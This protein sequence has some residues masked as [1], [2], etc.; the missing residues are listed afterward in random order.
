MADLIRDCLQ[1]FQLREVSDVEPEWAT[2]AIAL[3]LPP[4][5]SWKNR[6][7][8]WVTLDG[9]A[10]FLLRR[11][12]GGSACVGTHALFAGA[13]LAQMHRRFSLLS[14][15]TAAG[16]D[17]LFAKTVSSLTRAQRPDG[18]W[19][20]DWS[21]GRSAHAES[22]ELAL[23]VT[24]HVLESL[25]YIPPHHRVPDDVA[26][27]GLGFLL[28]AVEAASESDVAS[29]YCPY[30]HAARVLLNWPV[31]RGGSRA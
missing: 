24:G 13:V 17:A 18:S 15:E 30:S 27:R 20:G 2:T 19:G 31:R 9:L 25:M 11:Q 12:Q 8:D 14:A 10:R 29:H 3:Y 1:N 5:S 4:I 21:G 6:W 16:L 23:L 28:K 22:S 7:G 26:A